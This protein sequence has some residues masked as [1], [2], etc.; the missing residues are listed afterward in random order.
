VAHVASLLERALA[1]AP[2]E[3]MD[4]ETARERLSP[5]VPPIEAL[6]AKAKGVFASLEAPTSAAVHPR[7][8]AP[9]FHDGLDH[10]DGVAGLAE[11]WLELATEALAFASLRRACLGQDTGTSTEPPPFP[12]R[13]PSPGDEEVTELLEEGS[14]DE[15]SFWA[16][17]DEDNED[18]EIIA[19]LPAEDTDPGMDSQATGLAAATVMVQEVEET[20]TFLDAS[21]VAL[22]LS[23]D[24][25]REL[26]QAARDLFRAIF[27]SHLRVVPSADASGDQ[28]IEAVAG[29]CPAGSTSRVMGVQNIKGTG[30]DFVY[31][32]VHAVQPLRWAEDLFHPDRSVQLAS[33]SRLERWRE[34]SI[35]TCQ[36]IL[37]ALQ[38]MTADPTTSQARGTVR[39]LMETEIERRRG[40]LEERA[41]VFSARAWLARNAWAVW[42][43]FD[44]LLRRWQSDRIWADL[45][46]H[47]IS[48]ARAAH[49]LA[50]IAG[51][52]RADDSSGDSSM[53]P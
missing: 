11:L 41:R 15:A 6:A 25:Q 44:A 48:N 50:A 9:L 28:V 1:G 8:E 13:M 46:A 33:L 36:E 37:R 20:G 30:L 35:P 42:D 18:D 43:P 22:P 5:L 16:L 2:A 14:A 4:L 27:L 45:A 17:D 34:W 49:Q 10:Q 26:T 32:W 21:S 47:R 39:D 31:R 52:Q 51:R 7:L 53:L 24:R 12:I 29:C 40:L 23:E 38:A 3:P 19:A